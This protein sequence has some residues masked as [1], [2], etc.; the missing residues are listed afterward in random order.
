[1][2]LDENGKLR[3]GPDIVGTDAKQAFAHCRDL[4]L[5]PVWLERYRTKPRLWRERSERSK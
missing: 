1:M 4:D 3:D 5:V 2:Y